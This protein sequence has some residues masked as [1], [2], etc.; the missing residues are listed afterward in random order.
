MKIVNFVQRAFIGASI[1]TIFNV[2]SAEGE[3]KRNKKRKQNQRDAE[4]STA[5]EKFNKSNVEISIAANLLVRQV[6]IIVIHHSSI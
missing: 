1:K 3:G 4:V 5:S 6:V 2:N